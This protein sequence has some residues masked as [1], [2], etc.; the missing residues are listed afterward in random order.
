MA[1]SDKKV[2]V[3]NNTLSEHGYRVWPGYSKGGKAK[4]SAVNHVKFTIR[5]GVNEIPSDL[6]ALLKTKSA[7]QFRLEEGI[8]EVV[9]EDI[10]LEVNPL[11]GMSEKEAVKTVKETYSDELLETWAQKEKRPK[12]KTALRAQLAAL[13]LPT[14]TT[15]APAAG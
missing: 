10:A 5:P 14:E 7:A 15:P 6:W 9:S 11:A 1:D 13:A 8:Y 4:R 2:V 12:V 3:K